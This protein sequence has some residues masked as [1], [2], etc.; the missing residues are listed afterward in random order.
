LFIYW[1]PIRPFR[2]GLD[3]ALLY[4]NRIVLISL[5]TLR[6]SL[7]EFKKLDTK[8]SGKESVNFFL[9]D[10]N[11]EDGSQRSELPSREIREKNIDYQRHRVALFRRL[12]QRYP[13]STREV[14]W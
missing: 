1:I 8:E 14:S 7:N 2:N 4:D 12:F 13:A 9:M 5:D 10:Y 6:K 11:S 3:S